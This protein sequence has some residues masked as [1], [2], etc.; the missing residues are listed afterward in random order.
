MA[1]NALVV[2]LGALSLAGVGFG[3]A[4]LAQNPFGGM[5]C[6]GMQGSGQ[7]P[8]ASNCPGYHGAGAAGNCLQNGTVCDPDMPCNG[9]GNS[10]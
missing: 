10:G 1:A 7:C 4:T 2:I 6:G 9:T 3:A 5:A 8:Q